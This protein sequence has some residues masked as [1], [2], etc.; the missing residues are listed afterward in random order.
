M[1]FGGGS[2]TPPKPPPPPI[3]GQGVLGSE[4]AQRARRAKGRSNTLVSRGLLFETPSILFP[5]L[6]GLAERLGGR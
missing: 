2:R 5:Q 4:V 3:L 6:K 1:P